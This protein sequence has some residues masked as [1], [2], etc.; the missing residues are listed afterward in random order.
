MSEYTYNQANSNGVSNSNS[1]STNNGN[2]TEMITIKRGY[3]IEEY[4]K[5]LDIQQLNIYSMIFKEC[6]SLFYGLIN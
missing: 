5:Y 2:T 4:Q 3:P 6:D 1:H